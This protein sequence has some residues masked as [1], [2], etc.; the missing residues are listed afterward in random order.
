MKTEEKR[1]NVSKISKLL[2]TNVRA[3]I[4]DGRMFTGIFKVRFV[5]LQTYFFFRPREE[6]EKLRRVRRQIVDK[7]ANMVLEKS[8]EYKND[9]KRYAGTIMIPGTYNFVYFILLLLS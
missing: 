9:G 5:D 7:D 1:E 3:T 4:L 2:G 8:T 6:R